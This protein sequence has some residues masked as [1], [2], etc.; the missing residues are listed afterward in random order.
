MAAEEQH[1]RPLQVPAGNLY[2][3]KWVAYFRKKNQHKCFIVLSLVRL[4]VNRVEAEKECP[5][6]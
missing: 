5:N 3:L 4:L 2:S 6:S 1:K